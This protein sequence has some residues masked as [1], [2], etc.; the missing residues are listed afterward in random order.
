[1]SNNASAFPLTTDAEKDSEVHY[2]L[3]KREYFAG[4][5]MQG[6]IASWGKHDLTDFDDIAHDAVM[7][8]DALINELSKTGE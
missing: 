6:L 7:A 3:T 1:M 2:G 4:L 5:A 8:A